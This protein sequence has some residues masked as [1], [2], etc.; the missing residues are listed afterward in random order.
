MKKIL[1]LAVLIIA[2]PI[3]AFAVSTGVIPFGGRVYGVPSNVRCP[4]DPLGLS[5]FGIVPVS[6]S[7]PLWWSKS[8]GLV[9]VGIVAPS[10]WILGKYRP[11]LE[12]VQVNGPEA[13]PFPT[14]QTDFYGTSVPKP[15]PYVPL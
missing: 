4:G 6:V 8:Y 3:S 7:S 10:A 2:M 5:P 1:I 12:C 15:V 11:S 14:F 9:N 13:N